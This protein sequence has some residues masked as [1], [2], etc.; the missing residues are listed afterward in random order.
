MNGIMKVKDLQT[1]KIGWDG[2]QEDTIICV[3]PA[4]ESF[5][6]LQKLGND[7]ESYLT[8]LSSP[9]HNLYQQ[10]QWTILLFPNVDILHAVD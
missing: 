1:G 4:L 3:K 5:S 6:D 8:M 2:D 10:A 7:T 9:K